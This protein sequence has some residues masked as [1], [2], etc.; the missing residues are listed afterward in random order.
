MKKLTVKTADCGYKELIKVAQKCGFEIRQ[1]KKHC[2]VVSQE[3]VFI[4][5][6][7]RH[8]IVKRETAKG[9]AKRFKEFCADVEIG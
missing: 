8:S 4:T 6:V 3:G 9:I 5:T 1:G 2:K 7:P